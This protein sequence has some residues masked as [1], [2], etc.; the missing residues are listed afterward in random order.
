MS[1]VTDRIA[2]VLREHWPVPHGY[3][4]RCS[5]PCQWKQGDEDDHSAHVAELVSEALGLTEEPGWIRTV[6]GEVQ[7]AVVGWMSKWETEI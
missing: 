4:W 6:D 1:A 2:E 7:H 5:Y 3:Y